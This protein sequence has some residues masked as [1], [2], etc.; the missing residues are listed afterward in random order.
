MN[1]QWHR[2]YINT[3]TQTEVSHQFPITIIQAAVEFPK[4]VEHQSAV[5]LSLWQRYFSVSWF[6]YPSNGN[7]VTAT[8]HL[9]VACDF[10]RHFD[11]L[12]DRHIKTDYKF[13]TQSTAGCKISIKSFCSIFTSQGIQH[14]WIQILLSSKTKTFHALKKILIFLP[15]L[16]RKLRHSFAFAETPSKVVTYYY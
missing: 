7:S 11:W 14:Q 16:S 15:R 3:S 12:T 8:K 9:R 13:W 5:S 4:L 10:W 2:M 6:T 1:I